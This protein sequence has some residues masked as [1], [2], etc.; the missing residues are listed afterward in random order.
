MKICSLQSIFGM[1]LLIR[2]SINH[3]QFLRIMI[4]CITIDLCVSIQVKAIFFKVYVGLL[5]IDLWCKHVFDDN[6]LSLSIFLTLYVFL[7]NIN[8]NLFYLYR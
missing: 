1:Y 2:N 3:I 6:I 5:F 8:C 4:I 7:S